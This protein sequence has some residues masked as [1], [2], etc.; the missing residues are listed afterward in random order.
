[1][2][3]ELFKSYAKQLSILIYKSLILEVLALL[4]SC[5]IRIEKSSHIFSSNIEQIASKWNMRGHRLMRTHFFGNYVWGDGE[6][7]CVL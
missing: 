4:Y 2:H 6:R 5:V 1:V 3:I 7:V